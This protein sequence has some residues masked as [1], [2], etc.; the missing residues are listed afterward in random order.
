MNNN[1]GEALDNIKV[2]MN[3][4][5]IHLTEETIEKL[6]G[7]GYVLPVKKEVGG[8]EYVSTETLD[9]KG[10]H[11]IVKNI[12]VMGPHRSFDQ[13]ELLASDAIRLGVDA[14]V[15][16]SG[17]LENAAKITLVGPAGEVTLKCGMINARHVHL[18]EKRAAQLGIS[19]GDLVDVTS[20]GTRS[21][22]FHNVLVR[23]H[24]SS[25][26]CV[27]HFDYEEGNAAGLK[28]GDFLKLE[29]I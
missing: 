15:V 14:P 3:N 29:R 10:P 18:T 5:H 7:K 1:E 11:G 23:T 28:N 19:P 21:V 6:F 4:H 16:E 9:V 25:N 8:G 26:I 24:N 22:T 12:R 20:S 2:E 17:Y 27:I 13:V